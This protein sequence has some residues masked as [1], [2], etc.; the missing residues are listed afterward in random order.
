MTRFLNLNL[1]LLLSLSSASCAQEINWESLPQ[2]KS[3]SL[4]SD[5][6][7]F[8][9]AKGDLLRTTDG[10]KNWQTTPAKT[11]GGFQSVAMLNEQTGFAVNSRGKVWSSVDGGQTW[12][13]K[14][15][16]QAGDW[17]FNESNQMQFM[18]DLHGWI[19]EALTIWRTEDGGVNWGKA[20]SPFENKAKGQP[21]RGFF[22]GSDKAWVCGTYGELYITKDG[23]KT[24]ITQQVS[25]RDATFT[26]VFFVDE[27]TG[28]LA[29]YYPGQYNNLL[30][31]TSDGGKSWQLL[32]HAIKESSLNSTYFLNEKEGWAC[33]EA[34]SNDTNGHFGRGVLL[35]TTDGGQSWQSALTKDDDFFFERVWFVDRQHAWLF[36]RDNVYR[37][38]DG[39]ETWDVVLKLP[40]IKQSH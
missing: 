34:W 12:A 37:T 11:I 40:P 38:K 13:A 2:I 27:N 5:R 4:R 7:W 24:W 1:V 35:H 9:T 32:P 20:F 3:M 25:G 36:G 18:D 10:G 23:G 28:W 30:Y 29:G 33:G 19:V 16:L 8:V 15:E 31:R 39:G 21:V 6:S 17:H 22:L 26:D 14:S